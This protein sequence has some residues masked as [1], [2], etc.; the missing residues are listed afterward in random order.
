MPFRSLGDMARVTKTL[1][2]ETFSEVMLIFRISYWNLSFSIFWLDLV[3]DLIRQ[4]KT[5]SFSQEY[6]VNVLYVPLQ[7][8]MVLQ[9]LTS[10]LFPLHHWG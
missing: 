5:V 7:I 3:M 10:A 4:A 6:Q 8:D 9:Y 2:Y 1:I